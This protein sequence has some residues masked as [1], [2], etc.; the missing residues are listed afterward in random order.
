[1]EILKTATIVLDRDD[2]CAAIAAFISDSYAGDG[3][4]VD[5]ANIEFIIG[6]G[7]GY[8]GAFCAKVEATI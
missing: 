8:T 2:I 5:P 4:S 7:K 1:M 3:P 6:D